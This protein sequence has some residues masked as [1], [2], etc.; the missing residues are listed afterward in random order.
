MTAVS[1]ADEARSRRQVCFAPGT[2]L[3]A[4]WEIRGRR[5]PSSLKRLNQKEPA[6]DLEPIGAKD[7]G[8]GPGGMQ[9]QLRF[10]PVNMGRVEQELKKMTE[11]LLFGGKGRA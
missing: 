6:E 4:R 2:Q 1:I 3:K 8:E 10:D 9:E 5:A 11:Q 7:I